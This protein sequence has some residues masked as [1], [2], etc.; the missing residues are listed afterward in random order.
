MSEQKTLLE[1]MR[2]LNNSENVHNAN[3]RRGTKIL[4]EKD[5]LQDEMIYRRLKKHREF[6]KH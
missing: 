5:R 1:I 3:A 6:F 2:S 4:Q